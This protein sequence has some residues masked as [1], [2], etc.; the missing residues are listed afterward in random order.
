MNVCSRTAQPEGLGCGR[1]KLDETPSGRHRDGVTASQVVT[2][3]NH[4]INNAHTKFL[5]FASFH[6][7]PVKFVINRR[8]KFPECLCSLDP[9]AAEENPA[10]SHQQSA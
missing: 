2:G 1:N 7:L 9:E 6:L 8:L 4:H 10:S 5:M 3:I